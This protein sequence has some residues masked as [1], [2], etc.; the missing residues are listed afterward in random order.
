MVVGVVISKSKS[1][2]KVKRRWF[3]VPSANVSPA[4]WLTVYSNT[5]LLYSVN[6]QGFCTEFHGAE[7]LKTLVW[8]QCGLV[9]EGGKVYV[10]SSLSIHTPWC[11][12][13]C[14]RVNSE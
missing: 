4:D 1:Q 3:G 7:A 9:F 6:P 5:C 14:L 8:N 11:L 2:A 13:D 10:I 12:M